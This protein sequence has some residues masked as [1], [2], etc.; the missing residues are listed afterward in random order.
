MSHALVATGFN[1]VP[2][3]RARRRRRWHGC[4][5]HVRDIRRIGSAALD[6]CALADGRLD[7]YVEQ[8][9]APWDI[10]AGGLIAQRP[11]LS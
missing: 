6:L 2:E 8:G 9:L 11:G 7:A 1:Y 10:A 5:P 4:W 3:I